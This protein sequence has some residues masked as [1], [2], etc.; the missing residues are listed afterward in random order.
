MRAMTVLTASVVFCGLL[1]LCGCELGPP[2]GHGYLTAPAEQVTLSIPSDY[3][4]TVAAAEVPEH[5]LNVA[6]PAVSSNHPFEI[7]LVPSTASSGSI[8]VHTAVSPASQ[9]TTTG[10]TVNIRVVGTRRASSA[11]FGINTSEGTIEANATSGWVL[12]RF[13]STGLQGYVILKTDD[14]RVPADLREMEGGFTGTLRA[15]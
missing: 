11:R 12:V 10:N 3:D 5:T 9:V 4:C 1:A 7:N 2:S 13:T 6:T 8:I 15:E 14:P